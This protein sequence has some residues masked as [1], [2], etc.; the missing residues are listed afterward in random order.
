VLEG[1]NAP[2]VPADAIERWRVLLASP[3]EPHRRH[4]FDDELR[5]IGD[6][7]HVKLSVFPDG[8]VARL[9]VWGRPAVAP[10]IGLGL[11]NA[12]KPLDA[13]TALLRCCG[14]SAWTA[15]MVAA[16][17]FENVP[18]LLRMA[19]RAWFQLSEN[20]YLEA[21]AA[22][23]RIGDKQAQGAWSQR[24]QGQVATAAD[25]V[26][27]ELAEANQA[28]LAKHGFIYIVCASGRSADAML[29]DLRARLPRS[30]ADELRTATEEQAKITWLRLRELVK[31]LS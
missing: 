30:R 9:R 28:Y 16:R 2:G 26:L 5:R 13:T 1:A 27:R 10:E 15:A 17:P 18:T 25:N 4:V 11:L 14:S 8:G 12:M 31:E 21:F 23:P 3:L 20:D 29:A 24:E 7:T 19:E 22:H 6:V